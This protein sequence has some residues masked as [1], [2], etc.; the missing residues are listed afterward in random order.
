MTSNNCCMLSG[1]LL[2]NSEK[3]GLIPPQVKSCVHSIEVFL[4]CQGILCGYNFHFFRLGP[5]TNWLRDID[6]DWF[7]RCGTFLVF[8]FFL[9][10]INFFLL[11]FQSIV[12]PWRISASAFIYSFLSAFSYLFYLF[13]YSFFF[14]SSFLFCLSRLESS[15]AT[16]Y[17]L[18]AFKSYLSTVLFHLRMEII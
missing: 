7:I 2:I 17:H 18:S 6:F 11:S 4:W 15:F 12:L 3:K 1:Y 9:L 14:S 5:L 16:F 13:K 10:C 8:L